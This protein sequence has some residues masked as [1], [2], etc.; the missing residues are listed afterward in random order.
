MRPIRIVV[1]GVGKIARDQHLPTIA[2]VE[3]LVIDG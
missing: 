3:T 1:V 2:S